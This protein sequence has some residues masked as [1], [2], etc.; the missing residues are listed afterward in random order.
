LRPL[1]SA[2]IIP[3]AILFLG[4]FDS[5]KVAVIT[6]GAL[7]PIL[8]NTVDG[9]RNIDPVLLDTARTLSL[10]RGQALMKIVVPGASP[11]VF[12]GMRISLAI[13]L[14]LSITVEMIAGNNGLGFYIL[15]WERSFHFREMYAGILALGGVGYMLN[16]AFL[17]VDRRIM[18]WHKGFRRLE[19]LV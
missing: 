5:M 3:V 19:N 15:D 8:L 2:A 4:I 6:F 1:P 17:L 16:H 11:G 7:W 9:V 14:I 13:A 12:T 10:T 18:R